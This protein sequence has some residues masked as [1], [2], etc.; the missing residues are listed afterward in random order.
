[1]HAAFHGLLGDGVFNA[2]GPF[3]LRKR[4]PL[5]SNY[6]QGRFGSLYNVFYEIILRL[7]YAILGHTAV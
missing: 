7:P 5:H 4:L 1:M 2:D 6:V 3:F